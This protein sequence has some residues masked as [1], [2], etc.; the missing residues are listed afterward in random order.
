METTAS[1]GVQVIGAYFFDGLTMRKFRDYLLDVPNLWRMPNL[2]KSKDFITKMMTRF[3][4][5]TDR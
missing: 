3:L 5:V 2:T 1:I 4:N